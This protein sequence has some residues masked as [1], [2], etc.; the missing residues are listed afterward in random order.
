MKNPIALRIEAIHFN[1]IPR[2]AGLLLVGLTTKL[3]FI[4]LALAT[5][6][7]FTTLAS[8]QQKAK[9]FQNVTEAQPVCYG[10]EYSEKHMSTRPAQ[11]VKRMRAKLTRIDEYNQNN[12]LL[13]VELKG[14]E[15]FYTTFRAHMICFQGNE[16]AIE[17]D[18]GRVSVELMADGQMKLN[19]E[20]IILEGGCGDSQ[21]EEGEPITRY[22]EPTR[23]GDEVFMLGRLPDSYCQ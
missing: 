7:L 12:L 21:E 19:N 4:I 20:G 1:Q 23:G 10:K 16:C 22:L 8:A 6:L 13:D 14:A 18:G 11:T 17:C 2:A 15:N 5:V 9:I 3:T